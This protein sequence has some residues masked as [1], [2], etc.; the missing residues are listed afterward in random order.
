L[1]AGSQIGSRQALAGRGRAL[2][3]AA[4]KIRPEAV[5][6]FSLH[7]LSICSSRLAHHEAQVRAAQ[8]GADQ[9]P[10]VANGVRTS[11]VEGPSKQGQLAVAVIASAFPAGRLDHGCKGGLGTR[12]PAP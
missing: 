10:I 7:S 9:V 4:W 2:H 3:S 8:Q 6:L 11:W 1:P 5:D 12:L